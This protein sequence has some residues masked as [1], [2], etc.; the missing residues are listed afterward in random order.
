MNGPASGGNGG[1]VAAT[2]T[3]TPQQILTLSVGGHGVFGP[4]GGSGGG[5]TNI[6]A[7]TPNQIIAGG[8]GG[9]GRLG[10]TGGNGNGSA[11]ATLGTGTGGAGGIGGIGGAGG[12][13]PY[14]GDNGSSGSG[15]AGGDSNDGPGG[16]GTGDGS[17]GGSNGSYGGAGGGGYGGGGAG[18]DD[19]NE[20]GGGGGGGSVGPTGAVVSVSSNG[21]LNGANGGN[22][23]IIITYTLASAPPATPVAP[24]ATAGNAS[25]SVTFA[26]PAN[27][28]NAI[29]GY[30]VVSNPAGGVDSNAGS[31]GL[32][33]S[34]TGLTNGVAY[35]FTVTATNAAGTSG[36]SPASNSVTPAAPV[37]PPPIPENVALPGV[38]G[39]ASQ[40]TVLDLT[41]GRGPSMT[42]CL[43]GT[44]KQLFAADATYV[45]Q[46]THGAAEISVGAQTISFYP[47]EASTSTGLGIGAFSASS[48]ALTVGTSCGTFTVA[49][50]V[51]NMADLGNALAALG[52]RVQVDAEGVFTAMVGDQ[53]YVVRPDYFVTQ[54]IAT[55]TPSLIFGADG[56]LRFTDSAGKVQIL[57]PAFLD[58]AGLQAA[59]V[60][61]YGRIGYLTIQ[62][63]G[64]G[65]FTQVDG[66]QIMV[67][68]EMALSLA[69]NEFGLARLV[70]DR[71]SHYLYLIG[72]YYQG[73]TATAQ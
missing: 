65:V 43:M 51:A 49:P 18:G 46:S 30:T 63:D 19:N 48:N 40:L 2:L 6:D 52:L 57:H 73:V 28:G 34:I 37:V 31:T 23:S 25:A 71:A 54:G 9:G 60:A 1:K 56:V 14:R 53:L 13:D 12:P 41:S 10:A 55:G 47:F 44:V 39:I 35:T 29:T 38:P 36:V 58:P 11:G 16:T 17:G 21:G 61:T 22:G 5:S 32:T 66:S 68:P 64:S 7:G 33:H 70:N 4:N 8:G 15:G 24:T 42:T 59:I 45:G 62:S 50:A 20:G 26:A 27:N 69:P 67:T 3:V 72:A